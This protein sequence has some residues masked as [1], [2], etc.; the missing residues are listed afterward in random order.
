MPSFRE[1]TLVDKSDH[2]DPFFHY[3]SDENIYGSKEIIIA[4]IISKVC[5]MKNIGAPIIFDYVI[6]MNSHP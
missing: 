3:Y 6:S 1:F 5:F 4:D 2:Y